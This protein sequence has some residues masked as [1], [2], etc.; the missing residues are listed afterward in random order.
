LEDDTL[1]RNS[2]NGII[3]KK[4][5]L[6]RELGYRTLKPEEPEANLPDTAGKHRNHEWPNAKPKPER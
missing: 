5:P 3:Q 2:N 1:D 6:K 4:S